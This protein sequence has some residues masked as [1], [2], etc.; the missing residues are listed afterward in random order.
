MRLRRLELVRYGHL[1]DAVLD[2]PEG[3][4]LHVVLGA[5]EAGKSTALSAI[6]DALFGFRHRSDYDFL[7]GGPN[8]RIEF[9]LQATD[10]TTVHYIRRK[11][12]R[13]TLRDG[14]DDVIPEAALQPFLRGATRELFEQA[15]GLNAA[16]LR[17]GATELRRS[18]G[19]TGES[20]LAGLGLLNVRQALERIDSE[21]KALVGDGRGRRRLA[22]AVENYD[23]ARRQSEECAIPPRDWDAAVRAEAETGKALEEI[24]EKELELRTESSR[25]HR[26]RR[27]AGILAQL[28]D[29]R[30][31]LTVLADA[32]I[33][34]QDTKQRSSSGC[35]T[36]SP[37]YSMMML[38]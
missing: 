6:G 36:N 16:R 35:G 24:Q 4:L 7:H 26:V 28:G 9:T 14:H 3:A 30:D 25:L 10:G 21:A 19:E 11:G 15:F 22:E 8:L 23:K 5:N 27:I 17:E 1:T 29:T 13:D 32:P 12:R 37:I 38:C 18:G 2:F 34:P 31:R 33:L 20:L